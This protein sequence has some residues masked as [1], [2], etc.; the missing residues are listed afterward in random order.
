[1]WGLQESQSSAGGYKRSARP[2]ATRASTASDLPTL[3]GAAGGGGDGGLGRQSVSGTDDEGAH[4]IEDPLTEDAEDE[5]SQAEF[6]SI[7][8]YSHQFA[9]GEAEKAGARGGEAGNWAE[10]AAAEEDAL[11]QG[12]MDSEPQAAISIASD[13]RSEEQLSP[14]VGP[15]AAG[16]A[17]EAAATVDS[18]RVAHLQSLPGGTAGG[19]IKSASGHRHLRRARARPTYAS[20]HNSFGLRTMRPPP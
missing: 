4:L 18:E 2:R 16:A 1:M 20:L 15:E 6:G 14:K 11:E 13:P 5:V 8:V 3:R 17:E 7:G 10:E 12:A 19:S 9:V